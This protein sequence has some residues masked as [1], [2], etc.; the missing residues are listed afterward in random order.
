MNNSENTLTPL[1]EKLTAYID[2]QLSA[3]EMAAF[4]KE[5]AHLLDEKDAALRVNTLLK[6]HSQS[7]RLRNPDF[8][9]HQIIAQITLPAAT[10]PRKTLFPL[11]RLVFASACCMLAVLGIYIG[12]VKDKPANRQYMAQ[13]L[14]VTAGDE[15]LSA[16]LIQADGISVVWIDGFDYLSKDYVLE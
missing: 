14:K 1:E 4:E 5:H 7:P 15:D 16:E 9:N 13:V 11:W 6:Q 2:G 8:F 3:Q 12:F 10:Q